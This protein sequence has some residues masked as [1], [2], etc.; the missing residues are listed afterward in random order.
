MVAQS[1]RDDWG[2]R[3]QHVLP[4]RGGAAGGGGDAKVVEEDRK[5]VGVERLPGSA[6][7]E[8]PP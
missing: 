4:D 8:Q 3:L 6:A 7:R 5:D 1:F 2:G